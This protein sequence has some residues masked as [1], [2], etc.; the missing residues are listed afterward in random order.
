MQQARQ[1]IF[2]T[3]FMGSGKS[4][5]GRNLA[6]LLHM[7]FTDLDQYIEEHEQ[8]TI[9]FIFEQEGEKRFRAIEA[10]CLVKV[11]NSSIKSVVALGGGT[12]CFGNNLELVKKS[13][14]LVYIELTAADL[15]KRLKNSIKERPLLKNI[16][17]E[18]LVKTI[19]EKLS[20]RESFY[21]EA[22]LTVKGL[23]LTAQTLQQN[24]IDY[25]TE[26]N[27]Y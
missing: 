12:V 5:L 14:F 17:K 11:L 22:H 20:G 27:A 8:K 15:A 16:Q 13:G 19:S 10:A 2:L 25:T 7:P 18:D 1:H 23:H 26:N 24:I 3:G 4:T 21:R 9:P 6:E